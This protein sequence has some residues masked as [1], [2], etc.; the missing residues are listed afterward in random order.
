MELNISITT[1]VL[2]IDR[3]CEHSGIP[4]RTAQLMIA[5]GEL[6]IMPKKNPK[7]RTLVNMVAYLAKCEAAANYKP[8]R[9]RSA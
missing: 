9:S 6:P 2:R 4:M 5:N 1:P 7:E 3:F 8:R